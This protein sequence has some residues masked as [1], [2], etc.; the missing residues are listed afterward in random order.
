MHCASV[1]MALR[2]LP[3]AKTVGAQLGQAER[4]LADITTEL[5]SKTAQDQAMLDR[6]ISLAASVELITAE[7]SFRFAATAAYDNL[8]RE[9]IA[10]LRLKAMLPD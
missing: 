4:E 3:V 5:Q 1:I 9:R 2:G 8:V 7:H 6:L 10:E